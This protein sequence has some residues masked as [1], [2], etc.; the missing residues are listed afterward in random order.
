MSDFINLDVPDGAVAIHWFEQSSFAI[1]SRTGTTILVDP[2]FP[3]E[4]PSDRFIY[5]QPPVE[6]AEFPTDLV[7]L[8]HDHKDLDYFLEDHGFEKSE[9]KLL[10]DDK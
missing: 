6:E 1:K 10:T 2:Y 3:K 8:T 9:K 5:A 4:R 7:L